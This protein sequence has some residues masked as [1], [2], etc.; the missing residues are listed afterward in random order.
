MYFHKIYFSFLTISLC[1]GG[2][3]AQLP[4]AEEKASDAPVL[5]IKKR[6]SLMERSTLLTSGNSWVMIP[7]TAVIY[8]PD[9]YSNK[10][11]TKPKGSLMGWNAFL[12][13]NSGWIHTHEVTVQQARGI[14]VI[15][16]KIIQAYQGMGKVVIA[17]YQKNPIT[18]KPS[19]LIIPEKK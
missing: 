17:T 3:S 4:A 6:P 10:V 19:S 2:V 13:K 9:R 15:D 14:E 11:V 12:R 18:V 16:Q 1:L 8:L 5:P 7:K